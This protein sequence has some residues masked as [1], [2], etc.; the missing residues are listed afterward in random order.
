M[1][2]KNTCI[3]SPSLELRETAKFTVLERSDSPGNKCGVAKEAHIRPN[4]PVMDFM[5][6]VRSS[7]EGD[8]HTF[9]SHLEQHG[10]VYITLPCLSL[11][12]KIIKDLE[13]TIETDFFPP[14]TEL[15]SHHQQDQQV[16]VA[17]LKSG[18]FP[19]VSERGVPMYRLGYEHCDS[20]REAFRVHCG[21]PDSQPWPCSSSRRKWLRGMCLC[22]YICDVALHLTLGYTVKTCSTGS[23][24]HS[25]KTEPE[26]DDKVS[27]FA[28]E[29]GTLPDRKGDYSV[30]YAMHY[31][32]NNASSHRDLPVLVEDDGVPLNVKSH[33]N[34][35]LFVL[36][37]YLATVEGLQVRPTESN[38]WMTVDG[39]S[40]HV[41]DLIQR[42]QQHKNEDV[43]PMALF[44]GRAFAREAEIR[45]GRTVT[46]TLHRVVSPRCGQR[47]T[48]AIYEQKYEEYFPPP[49]LD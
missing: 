13:Q 12:A 6:L 44:V 21:S 31:F 35:S 45:C 38:E 46:P 9:W 48:V 36:E 40:S 4:L 27:Y 29:H 33:V 7:K 5:E 47:R 32:N 26:Q 41:H 11:P 37:P 49:L 15:Q 8:S 1:K 30:M 43:L 22:R 10:Y 39:P 3:T 42:I 19:Y 14:C 20:I 16:N 28:R 18:D 34:P 2:S 17:G 23:G 24:A 25:W